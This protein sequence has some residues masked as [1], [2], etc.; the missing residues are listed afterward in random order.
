MVDGGLSPDR[1]ARMRQVLAGHVARGEMPGLVAA[2]H[3]HG[4]TH[5][6]V[7]GSPAFGDAAPLQRDAI[8]R[9]ASMTKPIVAA[10][11]MTL[12]EDCVIHLH[13]PVQN[14]LPELANR[15]VLTRV[16]APLDD[17][18]PAVRPI[19][20]RDLLT[21]R[22]GLGALM[23]GP[24]NGHPIQAAMHAAGLSPGPV[25][26]SVEPDEW[27]RR[28]G[29]LPLMYQPGERW[30]YHTGSDVLGVLIARASGR[31]LPDL[32]RERIFEPLGM[33]DTGF[34][35]PAEKLARLT[36][37][38]GRDSKTGALELFDGPARSLFA[39]PPPF[40]S[41]GG[42]L[43]STVDDCLAFGRMMLGKGRLGDTRIL[44]RPTVELMTTDQ[45][46]PEQKVG[47]EMFFRP[48]RSWGFGL[49]VA[50]AH[51]TTFSAPGRFGWDGGLGTSAYTDPAEQLTGVLLTTRALDSPQPPAV[52]SDFWTGL[53][54]AIDD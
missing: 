32:L 34:H 23:S 54:A 49:S 33:K 50:T 7:L 6:E 42:G 8:F 39:V 12:V 15:R 43:V 53:Y 37:C 45:L 41:G 18:V 16:D 10:A 11:A 21:F 27:M 51:E 30:L 3:R 24:P 35:V 38:Y 1:L 28:L 36:A 4:H 19:T 20:V 52:F 44:A 26:A 48:T 9:I 17:T 25:A 14:W 13:D 31:S 40:P 2:A 5:V 47:S 46:T 22:L 29:E